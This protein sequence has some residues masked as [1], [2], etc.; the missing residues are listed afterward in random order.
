MRDGWESGQTGNRVCRGGISVSSSH[1]LLLLSFPTRPQLTNAQPY[2]CSWFLH[3]SEFE[4]ATLV[5]VF[6]T[7]LALTCDSD[8]STSSAT[9]PNNLI[10][11][12]KDHDETNLPIGVPTHSKVRVTDETRLVRLNASWKAEG[13]LLIRG[14]ERRPTLRL[15]VLSQLKWSC[16]GRNTVSMWL[17]QSLIWECLGVCVCLYIYSIWTLPVMCSVCSCLPVHRL[18]DK[19]SAALSRQLYWT[20]AFKLRKYT[21]T[22]LT[23]NV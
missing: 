21:G 10:L 12:W 13:R 3:L 14:R 1:L 16:E 2:A 9:L 22:H 20:A 19:R 8:A 18:V 6:A 7:L 11:D 23:T 4:A 15:N 5:E 17:I